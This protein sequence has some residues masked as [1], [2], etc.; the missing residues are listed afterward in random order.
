MPVIRRTLSQTESVVLIFLRML[1]GRRNLWRL[2]RQLYFS[3]RGDVVNRI[4][5]NG[6]AWLQRQIL[7]VFGRTEKLIVLDIGAN[8]GEWA[9]SLLKQAQLENICDLR[10]YSF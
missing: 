5:S 10:I 9:L 7:N 2:G 4:G 3:A 6:E 1:L 8:I